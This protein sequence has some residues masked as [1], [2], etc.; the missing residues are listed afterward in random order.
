MRTHILATAVKKNI[1]RSTILLLS[2]LLL[3]SGLLVGSVRGAG[4]GD[5]CADGIPDASFTLSPGTKAVGPTY[6]V[7]FNGSYSTACASPI[8]SYQWDFGDGNT[9][10]GSTTNH[11]YGVGSFT[12]R[13]TITDEAGLTNT[14]TYYASII[15]K[16]TNQAPVV[17]GA[18]AEVLQGSSSTIDVAGQA[19]DPDGDDLTYGFSLASGSYG[20]ATDKGWVSTVS[21]TGKFSYYANPNASGQDSF[22]IAVSDGFGGV[23]TA[24]V[25]VT[26]KQYVTAVADTATTHAGEP[27]TINVLGNDSSY[28]GRPFDVYWWS[29]SSDGTL[30]HNQDDSFGFTPKPGFVGTASFQYGIS[31]SEELSAHRSQTT[32]A[33]NVLPAVEPPFNNPPMANNDSAS[34][35]EDAVVAVNVLANDTDTEDGQNLTVELVAAPSHGS[36][37][38]GA[39]RSFTY[40]PQ[41]NFNGSDSFTYRVYDSGGKTTQATVNI[42]IA[43]VNDGPAA[44][45]SGTVSKAGQATFNASASSDSDGQIVSYRWD[46]GDGQSATTTTVNSSHKYANKNGLYQVTLTVTDNQGATAAYAMTVNVKNGMLTPVL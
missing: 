10:A 4:G 33:I 18:S 27:V 8:V 19:T 44:N 36:A 45:F 15:V 43:S 29:G 2:A 37:V 42:S 11:Q 16:A 3:A 26:I 7:S 30:V 34:V 21:S 14:R 31:D 22:E 20:H 24:T 13:L 6:N 9:A 28:D 32:V 25:T 1:T 23:G 38:L 17:N 5:P 46:F 41:A 39:N 12:P 35:S 40:T